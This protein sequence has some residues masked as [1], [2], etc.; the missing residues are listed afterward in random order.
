MKHSKHTRAKFRII[1]KYSVLMFI[2]ALFMC[3]G[4]ATI[5][6]DVL[7]IEGQVTAVAQ[8][9][10]F[11]TDVVYNSNSGADIA[12]SKI[13]YYLGTALDSQVE[14]GNNSGSYIK[15]KVTVYNSTDKEQLF[16]GTM[17]DSTIPN[18]YTNNNIEY[19]LDEIQQYNTVIPPTTACS[20]TQV[21]TETESLLR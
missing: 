15:Y 3:I 8:E 11:I 19:V 2:A 4:Y 14:L 12:N 9:G 5:T 20:Q 10:V 1:E 6:G 16:I 17:V 7:K 13:N 21:S 18:T